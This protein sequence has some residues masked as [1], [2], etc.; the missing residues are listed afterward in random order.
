MWAHLDTAQDVLWLLC[1]QSHG[2]KMVSSI[3]YLL[4]SNLTLNQSSHLFV[5]KTHHL[6]AQ[7]I[8]GNPD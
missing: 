3:Q 7:C 8:N 1:P 6:M 4:S 2:V 5:A